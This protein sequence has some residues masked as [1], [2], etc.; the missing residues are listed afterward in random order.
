[1]ARYLPI[2]VAAEEVGRSKSAIYRYIAAGLLKKYRARGIDRRT[3]VDVEALKE[4]LRNPP[5]EEI[6][7]E[8][9]GDQA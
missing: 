1:M 9:S 6:R 2:A 8:E 5:V 3:L 4:L 7:D